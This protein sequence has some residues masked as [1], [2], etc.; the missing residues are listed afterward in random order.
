MS[1]IKAIKDIMAGLQKELS[2]AKKQHEKVQSDLRALTGQAASYEAQVNTKTRMLA[3]LEAVLRASPEDTTTTGKRRGRPRKDAS[4]ATEPK[5]GRP[6]KN[7][8]GEIKVAPSAH[9]AEG[10]R[11]VA[12]GVRPPI[13]EA[14]ATV[15]GDRTMTID[16]IFEGLRAKN[17]LPNSNEPRQ[18]ISYLLSTSKERFERVRSAGR[19][20]YRGKTTAEVE[21]APKAPTVRKR[22]KAEK[23]AEVRS[24]DEIL[25]ESGVLGIPAFGG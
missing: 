2:A 22:I 24:T 18:Y 11:A 3:D 14:I 9:I 19:G 10:R 15:M 8:D 16:E 5:R 25:A 21:T 4:I 6:R 13:K 7:V 17:W 12:E 1:T 23:V 20:V